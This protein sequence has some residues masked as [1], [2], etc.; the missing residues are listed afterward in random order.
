MDQ[1]NGIGLF[2]SPLWENS[3]TLSLFTDASGSLGYGGFFQKRWFQGQWLP[4][5]QLGQ[6]G[7]SILW[8]EL[9]A[10][11]IACHLWGALWTSKRIRFYFDNQGVVE[12][13]NSRRSKVPRVMDLVRDLTLCTLRCMSLGSITTLQTL[14]LVSRWNAST[15]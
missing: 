6:P 1:W 9:Y 5:Q 4:S 11:N 2:L 7:I 14:F 13:I 10:I 8:Q 3:D 15:S 12:V